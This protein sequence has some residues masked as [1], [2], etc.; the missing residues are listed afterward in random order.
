M[1]GAAL[2][3]MAG[4][5]NGDGVMGRRWGVPGCATIIPR[6]LGPFEGEGVAARVAVEPVAAANAAVSAEEGRA[7]GGEL[8]ADAVCPGCCG[9][10]V[11]GVLEVGVDSP[12]CCVATADTRSGDGATEGG[13]EADG[14]GIGAASKRG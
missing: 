2:G 1:A 6:A 10:T 12:A 5:V 4:E 7:G 3:V 11:K 13:A 8:G 14:A 9:G